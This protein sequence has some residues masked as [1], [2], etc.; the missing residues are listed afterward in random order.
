ME[1]QSLISEF[2]R[3]IYHDE[4]EEF[5]KVEENLFIYLHI[6]FIHNNDK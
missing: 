2:N 3:D 4:K 5:N 1:I 6:S